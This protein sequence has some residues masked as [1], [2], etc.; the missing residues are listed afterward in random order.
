MQR[1]LRLVHGSDVT[2]G[3]P[4]MAVMA[5]WRRDPFG[6]GYHVWAAGSTAWEMVPIARQPV[7]GVNLTICGEA[8]SSGQGW[9][10]GAL[11]TAERALQE[12]LGLAWPGWL[13]RDV[14]LG[15]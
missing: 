3:E 6:A 2:I 15:P 5:D 9:T 8:W 12:R 13:P 7:P 4:T 1:Q 10:R 11:M 14:D